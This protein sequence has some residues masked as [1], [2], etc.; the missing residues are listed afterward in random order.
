MKFQDEKVVCR[1]WKRIC[2]VGSLVK[3]FCFEK[4]ISRIGV[5]RIDVLS[6]FFVVNVTKSHFPT[7]YNAVLSYRI[8][9]SSQKEKL[10]I[11]E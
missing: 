6:D 7:F 4:E 10:W 8:V 9:N 1:I 11:K 5:K 2:A 3:P